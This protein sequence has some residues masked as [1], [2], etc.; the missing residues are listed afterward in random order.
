MGTRALPPLTFIVSYAKSM[1]HSVW[2]S[3]ACESGSESLCM[4]VQMSM[5]D[6]ILVG[7]RFQPKQLQ[8]WSK[9]KKCFKISVWQFASCVN[10]SLKS[11][12]VWLATWQES[13]IRRVHEKCHSACKSA[14]V[15]MVIALKNSWKSSLSINKLVFY[16]KKKLETLF[17]RYALY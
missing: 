7:L 14:S 9:N 17:C 2:T 12:R 4:D 1:G 10:G 15:T 8:K 5:T 6:S 11:V 13:S 16:V 3:K